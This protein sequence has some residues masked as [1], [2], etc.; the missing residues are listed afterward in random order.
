[1]SYYNLISLMPKTAAPAAFTNTKSILLDGIDDY[2]D[3][4]N[5]TSLQITGALTISAWVKTTNTST[6]GVVVGKDGVS[7]HATRSYQIQVQSSGTA[8]FVIFK[9]GSV[10][11]LV[12]GTTL[13]NDGNWHHVMGVN[14]GIDL[15]IYVDG[16]LE[17][18][19]LGG[20]GTIQ[21][22]TANFNIGRRQGN[23]TNELEFLGNIDEVA[24]WNSDQS[25]NATTIYNSGVPND[26][27]S[28]SPLSWWR[29]GDGDTS[30]IL[31]DNGSGSNDGTMT[32]FTTFSTDVP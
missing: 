30:P 16:T 18:T 25:A 21:N 10:V 15:K 32:N 24:I 14:D 17:A 8:R 29:C 11:E 31:T 5:P 27:S 6:N 28:L 22:G 19:D 3:C 9:S 1:M 2:V 4:G 20:G 26:I 12:T 23:T 13:V 7:P